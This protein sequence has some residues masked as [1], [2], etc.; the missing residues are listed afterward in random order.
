MRICCLAREVGSGGAVSNTAVRRGTAPDGS[1][2]GVAGR[3]P[4]QALVGGLK[5]NSDGTA[6]LRPSMTW[7]M[8]LTY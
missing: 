4:S 5:S 7:V 3:R 8:S 2:G 1:E 6:M